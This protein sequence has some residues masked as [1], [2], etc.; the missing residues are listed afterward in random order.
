MSGDKPA[1]L[2]AVRASLASLDRIAVDYPELID[3][4]AR[5]PA[6]VR[7]W[8]RTLAEGEAMARD[9]KPET[10]GTAYRLP[11]TLIKR[12]EAYAERM[13]VAAGDASPNPWTSTDVVRKVLGRALDV[14][15]APRP[16]WW[17]ALD[18]ADDKARRAAILAAVQ[19]CPADRLERIAAV[20]GE[21]PAK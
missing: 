17:S 3:P 6:S 21:D 14:L 13:T 11:V 4:G 5:G 9:R 20:L 15:E 7:A 18:G 16:A 10:K 1:D 2:G 12:I 8:E 19:T